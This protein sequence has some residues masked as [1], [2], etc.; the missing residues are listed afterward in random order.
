MCKYVNVIPCVC[1]CICLTDVRLARFGRT[2]CIGRAFFFFKSIILYFCWFSVAVTMMSLFIGRQKKKNEK[3]SLTLRNGRRWQ[4]GCLINIRFNE[5]LFIYWTHRTAV[6]I[7]IVFLHLFSMKTISQ[8]FPFR[9]PPKI[10]LPYFRYMWTEFRFQI[11]FVLTCNRK[12]RKLNTHSNGWV[13]Q[14]RSDENRTK[15]S[16]WMRLTSPD[17]TTKD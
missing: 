9:I 6:K 5:F 17:M 3:K 1:V 13:S 11:F 4:I 2:I 10:G 15:V 16:C 14:H 8:L 12:V 7:E